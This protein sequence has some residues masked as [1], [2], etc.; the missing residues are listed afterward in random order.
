MPEQWQTTDDHAPVQWQSTDDTGPTIG[1]STPRSVPGFLGNVLTSTGGLIEGAVSALTHPVQ[2]VS[3]I[4]AVPVGL[5]EKAG[6]P[7]EGNANVSAKMLDSL[8]DH[9]K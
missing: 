2:T 9:W 1:V 3:G 5:A 6:V 7:L 4:G 8:I